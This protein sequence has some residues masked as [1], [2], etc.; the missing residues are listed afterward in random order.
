MTTII[1]SISVLYGCGQF[2]NEAVFSSENIDRLI[3]EGQYKSAEEIIKIKIA[4]GS[5]SKEEI[6]DLNFKI[7]RM[8]RIRK[9]FSNTDSTVIA[10]IKERYPEVTPEELAKWEAEGAL[11]CKMIDGEKR[12]FWNAGR[13]LFR[14]SKEAQSKQKG[15]QGR[16][17]DEL[18]LFLADYIPSVVATGAK[19]KI[20]NFG[21]PK[22]FK[23]NYSITVKPNEVPA[24]E[25]IRVWLPYPREF[26]R[27]KNV[28]LLS[29]TNKNYII[30][31]DEYE[32]KSIYMEAEAIKD[33]AITFGYELELEVADHWFTFGPEDV[34]PYDTESELYKEY[35]AE[36]ETHVIFTPE[37]KRLADSLTAGETN[38][39]N[40]ARKIFDYIC[41]TYPW[42]SAREYSTL[43]NIPSY[44]LANNHGDCGQVG[45]T[46]ITMARYVGIP[47][48]WQSGWMLHPGDINLHDW[49]EA[50]FEGIGW[51]PVDQSF[52]RVPNDNDAVSHFYLGGIDAYRY[53]VNSDYSGN[54]FPAKNHLRSETVDFQRGEVEW[55]GENLY[56]GRWSYNMDVEYL[57]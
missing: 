41:K 14:I 13:N 4:T 49:A 22:K 46:F 40:K 11:E 45:L 10:Y 35:T 32:H 30:S 42:A 54:F 18:D 53:Y 17:S 23:I 38:P 26:N 57:N 47:A 6:Y 1:L 39:Y 15:I 25:M 52:G 8:N 55:R 37:I 27:S 56:F 9:D 12:Y 48:K 43:E 33:S 29:T 28:K 50:Y 20:E 7:D 5:L 2:S 3:D 19:G 44:V 36:R 16:Q 24:G 51:V 34:K 21:K 31:P